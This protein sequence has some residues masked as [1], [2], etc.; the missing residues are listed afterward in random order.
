M[1]LKE[2]QLI[3]VIFYNYFKFKFYDPEED[4]ERLFITSLCDS[5]FGGIKL[6]S[7]TQY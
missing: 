2:E 6:M 4:Q 7:D 1:G 3:G 5:V